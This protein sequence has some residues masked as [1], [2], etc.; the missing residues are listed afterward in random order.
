MAGLKKLLIWNLPLIIMMS[1]VLYVSNKPKVNDMKKI[2]VIVI[3]SLVALIVLF[4]QFVPI[5]P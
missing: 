5:S 2:F 1:A 3:G 4:K